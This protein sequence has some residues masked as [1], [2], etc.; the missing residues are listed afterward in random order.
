MIDHDGLI[1]DFKDQVSVLWTVDDE[2][3]TILYRREIT[4]GE[5]WIQKLVNY[6]IRFF[7]IY[8][9]IDRLSSEINSE[10]IPHFRSQPGVL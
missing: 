5:L 7:C 9:I 3:N 10:G 1:K 4:I 8:R 6:V 2:K